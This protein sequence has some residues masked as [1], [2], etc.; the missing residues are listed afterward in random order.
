MDY[1]DALERSDWALRIIFV[2]DLPRSRSDVDALVFKGEWS[3]VEKYLDS[4]KLLLL[5]VEGNFVQRVR[6]EKCGLPTAPH[7]GLVPMVTK[8]PIEKLLM[9]EAGELAEAVLLPEVET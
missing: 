4:D 7:P 3:P 5:F 6:A 2:M 9:N 1:T 8:E